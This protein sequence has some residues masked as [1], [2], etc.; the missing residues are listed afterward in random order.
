MTTIGRFSTG[1]G[2]G[3]G[4]SLPTR[5]DLEPAWDAIE[6]AQVPVV[7]ASAVSGEGMDSVRAALSLAIA[8]ES[9]RDVPAVTNVRHIEL[10]QQA[11]AGARARR[12]GRDRGDA[13]RVRVVGSERSAPPV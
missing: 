5:A 7:V 13:G 8:G 3:F 1:H 2:T 6:F 11:R 10:L 4:S 12:G 9:R